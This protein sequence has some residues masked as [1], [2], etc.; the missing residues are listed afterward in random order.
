MK[1]LLDENLSPRLLSTLS[2]IF[3]DSAHVDR[4]GLGSASD[5]EVWQYAKENDLTIISKDSDF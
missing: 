5:N 3:P 4:I 2:E 1:F